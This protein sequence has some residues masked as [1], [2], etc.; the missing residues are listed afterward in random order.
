MLPGKPQGQ[1]FD[2][3]DPDGWTGVLAVR[4]FFRVVCRDE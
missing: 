3:T 1:V 4:K 2:G